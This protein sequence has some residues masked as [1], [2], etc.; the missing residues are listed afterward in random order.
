MERI[1]N[2]SLVSNIMFLGIKQPT[3]AQANTIKNLKINVR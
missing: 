1:K 2:A 3:F